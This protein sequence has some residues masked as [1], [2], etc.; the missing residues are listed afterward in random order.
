M[1]KP[2]TILTDI[3][4][5]WHTLQALLKKCPKGRRI[6]L[7]GDLID[8]GPYSKQV[9]E[10]AM[11]RRIPACLGNHEHLC[12]DYHLKQ[13]AGKKS[14]YDEGIWL[15]N[16]GLGMLT[17]WTGKPFTE[18]SHLPATVI[19]WM[20]ALPLCIRFPEY[21]DLLLSHTGHGLIT[22]DSQHTPFDAVWARSDS[23]PDDGLFRVFGHT[24][25]SDPVITS[26]YANIDTGCAYGGKLTAF[27]WPERTVIDQQNID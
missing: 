22:P 10:W 5:S 2:L 11:R 23:F 4:G 8:R 9:V 26:R 21:P 12:V 14:D 20:A 25:H 18:H 17:K 1:S 27:L 15:M 16:G 13:L 3:H 6:V 24:P 19:A 7:L